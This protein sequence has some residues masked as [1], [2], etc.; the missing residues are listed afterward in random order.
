MMT[1]PTDGYEPI[2][3]APEDIRTINF[4]TNVSI[5]AAEFAMG[6]DVVSAS[7]EATVDLISEKCLGLRVW[8]YNSDYAEYLSDAQYA[9][10][11]CEALWEA[12]EGRLPTIGKEPVQ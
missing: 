11:E 12:S 5:N 1:Q 2:F 6:F 3:H 7:I 4:T 8:I 9:D 10:L